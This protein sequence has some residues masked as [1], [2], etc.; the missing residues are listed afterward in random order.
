LRFAPV[1]P[2]QRELRH[3]EQ[4]GR[5]DGHDPEGR[6]HLG[7]LGAAHDRRI[8]QELLALAPPGI[9]ELYA[10]ALIGE[11][12]SEGRFSTVIIDP[13][14]TG[15]L[16]RLL[17][18]PAVALDWSHRIMRLALK[19]KEVASFT[20]TMGDILTFAQRTRAVRD[21]LADPARATVILVTLDEPMVRSET[22]RLAAAVTELGL[23][24]SAVIW[25]RSDV[26]LSAGGSIPQF[27]APEESP[28]P[29]GLPALR[30]WYSRWRA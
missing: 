19:Y 20:D 9:D 30:S 11:T 6:P 7:R 16:L 3:A 14:P 4:H 22:E 5:D 28:S 21:L 26:P 2:Q 23:S 15:H 10:L 29:S 12:L 8:L 27:A 17:E 25:N 13:A 18:T 1:F 24:V